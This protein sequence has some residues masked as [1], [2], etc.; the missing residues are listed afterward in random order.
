V[1]G[2]ATVAGVVGLRP[3]GQVMLAFF[4][5]GAGSGTD[6]SAGTV[7]LVGGVA[8][9]SSSEGPLAAGSYSFQASYGGDSNYNAST[10]DCEPLTEIGRASWSERDRHGEGDSVVATVGVGSTV[11]GAGK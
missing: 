4:W 3:T 6:P 11:Q 7:S 5:S 1:H 2:L 9:P 8:H 10:S